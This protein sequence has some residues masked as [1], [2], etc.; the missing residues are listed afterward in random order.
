MLHDNLTVLA[1]ESEAL[2][3]AV[4]RWGPAGKCQILL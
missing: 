3:Q 1:A 2:E 4:F